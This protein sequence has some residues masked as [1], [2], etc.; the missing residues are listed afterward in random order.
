[1]E[2][3]VDLGLVKSIGVSNVSI[4]ELT[5]LKKTWKIAPAVNQVEAHPF[6][7]NEELAEAQ[8]KLA[9][10]ELTAYCPLGVGMGKADATIEKAVFNHPEVKKIAE[11]AGISSATLC[12]QW[13]LQRDTIVL[14]KSTTESRIAENA[15]TLAGG[16]SAEAMAKVNGLFAAGNS[17]RVCNPDFFRATKGPFFT[18]EKK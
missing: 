4:E 6:F 2:K 9:G 3:L 16:L 18:D 1:M 17:R 10:I 7:P 8:K 11:E 5:E 14:S 15:A 13:G 12:I